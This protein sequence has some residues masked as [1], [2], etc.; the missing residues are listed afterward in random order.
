VD[1]WHGT[2]RLAPATDGIAHAVEEAAA[3]RL[4][5][6]TDLR[7]QLFYTGVRAL[8]RLILNQRR[9]H[10]RVDCVRRPSQSIGN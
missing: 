7:L 9:L 2:S 3:S 8:E 10:K 5:L 1:R 4:L 6:A